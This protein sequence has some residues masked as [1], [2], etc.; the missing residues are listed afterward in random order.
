MKKIPFLPHFLQLIPLNPFNLYFPYFRFIY[1]YKAI[2]VL[3]TNKWCFFCSPD[4]VDFKNNNLVKRTVKFTLYIW[5]R[6]EVLRKSL[7]IPSLIHRIE[8]QRQWISNSFIINKYVIFSSAHWCKSMVRR[9]MIFF[10]ENM[11]HLLESNLNPVKKDFLKLEK[12]NHVTY[13]Q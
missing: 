10:L 6:S 11:P 8:G 7:I 12:K 1:N 2:F 5:G 4:S 13:G 3:W 9:L